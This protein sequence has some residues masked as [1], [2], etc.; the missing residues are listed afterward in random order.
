[1]LPVLS[2]T[3]AALS[4]KHHSFRCFARGHRLHCSYTVLCCLP[5]DPGACFLEFF[6]NPCPVN[7]GRDTDSLPRVFHPGCVLHVPGD[8]G[9]TLST[10]HRSI[11]QV[12]AIINPVDKAFVASG[13]RSPDRAYRSSMVTRALIRGCFKFAALFFSGQSCSPRGRWQIKFRFARFRALRFIHLTRI[14]YTGIRGLQGLFRE[15][16]KKLASF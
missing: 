8:H 13:P 15:F 12:H 3:S 1:M 16:Q 2:G 7:T 5:S 10:V 9:W 11:R 14:L 4:I 6:V